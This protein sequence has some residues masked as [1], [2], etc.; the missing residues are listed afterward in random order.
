MSA[1]SD[2]AVLKNTV[3]PNIS[4]NKWM[5][6]DVSHKKHKNS[7]NQHHVNLA[8]AKDSGRQTAAGVHYD[9]HITGGVAKA[10]S[11]GSPAQA[12]DQAK[13]NAAAA[14]EDATAKTAEAV[15]DTKAAA[16][17]KTE[18]VK[19]EASGL[20]AGLKRKI[21]DVKEAVVGTAQEGKQAA[22]D[23]VDGAKAQLPEDR[24]PP[25]EEDAIAQG[26]IPSN[27][28]EEAKKD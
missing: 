1:L 18:Q 22:A 12:A 11:N 13:D 15:E 17:E 3:D 20:L 25:Q 27:T 23:A 19:E 8:V 7:P 14:A 21:E 16:A 26:L 2:E 28:A 9:D 4:H 24:L 10:R 5:D 6:D